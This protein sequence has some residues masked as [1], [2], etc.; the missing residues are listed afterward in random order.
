MPRALGLVGALA[1]AMLMGFALGWW[2]SAASHKQAALLTETKAELRVSESLRTEEHTDAVQAVTTLD[3][4]ATARQA[5]E[6]RVLAARDDL[7]GLQQP[8]RRLEAAPTLAPASPGCGADRRLPVLAQLLREGAELVEEGARVVD[9]LR[10][11]RNSLALN[12]GGRPIPRN[13]NPSQQP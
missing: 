6:P 1:L 2:R 4:F 13:D 12:A 9:E 7:V 8:L 10:D 5:R 11:Q 3:R